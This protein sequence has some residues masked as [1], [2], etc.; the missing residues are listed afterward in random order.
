MRRRLPYDT[1]S[2]YPPYSENTYAAENRESALSVHYT[3]SRYASRIISVGIFDLTLVKKRTG[4]LKNNLNLFN[5]PKCFKCNKEDCCSTNSEKQSHEVIFHSNHQLC[6]M[7][8]II[9]KQVMK[10]TITINVRI[11][12]I[13]SASVLS[14]EAFSPRALAHILQSFFI[15]S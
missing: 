10:L 11:P 14:V 4:I 8:A 15:S 2:A 13:T 9:K 1:L 5:I 12:A 7:F 6:I 3:P